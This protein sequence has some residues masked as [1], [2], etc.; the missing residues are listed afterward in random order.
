MMNFFNKIKNFFKGVLTE[1]KKINWPNRSKI[2][3]YSLIVIGLAVFVA[4]FL[5]FFDFIF[6][7]FLN[8]IIF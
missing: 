3:R 5:G 2:L 4:V 8:K 7:K 1:A 6:M